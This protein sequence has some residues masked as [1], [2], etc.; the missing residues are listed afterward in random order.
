M[1]EP[2]EDVSEHPPVLIRKHAWMPTGYALA[3]VH[4]RPG[5]RYDG[6]LTGTRPEP[7]RITTATTIE[8]RKAL[9]LQFDE[10]IPDHHCGPDCF[11]WQPLDAVF[12]EPSGR[13]Q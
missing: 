12:G 9:E 13:I 7:F 8:C 3:T 10:D 4:K 6:S 2:I 1:L 11:D 5:G